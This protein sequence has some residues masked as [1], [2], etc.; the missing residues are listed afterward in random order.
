MTRLP[1]ALTRRP[2]S[3]ISGV[4]IAAVLAGG[5]AA[6][7]P[8]R[9]AGTTE[10]AV[11]SKRAPSTQ[12]APLT[13]SYVGAPGRN[14]SGV[15]EV[16]LAKS[17]KRQ[18]LSPPKPQ[19]G[20]RFGAAV[21]SGQLD[22][23]EHLSPNFVLVGA[24]GLTVDGKPDA[25]GIYVFKRVGETY[26]FVDLV[27]QNDVLLRPVGDPHAPG[28][29]G[30]AQ[31][32]AEFG[33]AL[34]GQ[35]YEDY[36]ATNVFAGAP[37]LDV[38]GAKAAGG[39][40]VLDLTTYVGGELYGNV[41]GVSGVL[42]TLD[43]SGSPRPP[44]PGDRLGAT[45]SRWW[46]GAPGA[47]VEGRPG[48][49]LAVNATSGPPTDA[50]SYEI[51]QL[52]QDGLPGTPEA[53][54]AFGSSFAEAREP[55]EAETVWIGA[56]GK[57]V[58]GARDAGMIVGL[59]RASPIARLR[60]ARTYTA[61]DV[62]GQRAGEGDRFGSSLCAYNHYDQKP[63]ATS[64][65]PVLPSSRHL[66]AGAPGKRVGTVDGAGAVV[67]LL[68]APTLTA[69]T[70]GSR[71]TAGAAFGSRLLCGPGNSTDGNE[72]LV[73]APGSAGTVAH[74]IHRHGDDPLT[75]DLWTAP[76]AHPSDAYGSSVA[77]RGWY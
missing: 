70:V 51:F 34:D 47:T 12:R 75:W 71:S 4:A 50:P 1:S 49:G 60:Y 43:L 22:E 76:T 28:V 15:V 46:W 8:P 53:G 10:T 20:E 14:G 9:P 17:G 11:A 58:E 13:D 63:S 35:V 30:Q 44:Q 27:T 77:V 41:D 64:F 25:G 45:V 73:G 66:F 37:G 6:D 5:C 2:L 72:L 3:A 38:G 29:P 69:E 24:P 40:F 18:E 62:P 36:G 32:G 52:G 39:V 57:D 48:A 42:H 16:R 65:E 55:N 7:Q 33:A 56:P 21:F 23:I 19:P 67:G 59:R 68:D 26:R 31:A 74:G 61:N 54:D